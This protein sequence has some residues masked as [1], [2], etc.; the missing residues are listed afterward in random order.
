M[1][2]TEFTANKITALLNQTINILVDEDNIFYQLVT[3]NYIH[4]LLL[5]SLLLTGKAGSI[6]NKTEVLEDKLK[7]HIEE[8]QTDNNIIIDLIKKIRKND[9]NIYDFTNSIFSYIY[10]YVNEFANKTAPLAVINESMK[11]FKSQKQQSVVENK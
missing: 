8:G 9:V 5:S 4:F 11:I 3:I 6:V 7:I 10:Q 2:S 1:D